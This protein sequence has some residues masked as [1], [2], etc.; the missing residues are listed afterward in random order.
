MTIAVALVLLLPALGFLVNA[1][2]GSWL[3]RRVHGIVATIAVGLAFVSSWV[4]LANLLGLPEADRRQGVLLY[5]WVAAPDFSAALGAWV[6]PLSTL[7]L[8][9]VTGIGFLIHLYRSEEHTSDLQS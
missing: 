4:V 9:I 7:M 1:L 2:L 5:E 8:L 6:D 3:P